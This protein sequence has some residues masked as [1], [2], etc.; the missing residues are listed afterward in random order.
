MVRVL[1]V[2]AIAASSDLVVP[3]HKSMLGTAGRLGALGV[4]TVMAAIAFGDRLGRGRPVAV[5]ESVS[6]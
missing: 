2:S 1:L 4:R 6:A 3:Q 5:R